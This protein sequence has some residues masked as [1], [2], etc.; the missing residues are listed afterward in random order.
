VEIV[1]G[2]K[3][4]LA[5]LRGT[6]PAGYELRIVRDQAEFIEASIRSVE[7]HLVVGSILAALVVLLFLGNLRS[8]VIA[9][10]S[11]PTSII[12]TFG[13]IGTWDSR[14]TCSRCWR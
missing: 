2:V 13:L 3:A 11:I 4:R 6:L 1:N 9:A 8:T 7:E 12:A 10:V 5:V 14:S